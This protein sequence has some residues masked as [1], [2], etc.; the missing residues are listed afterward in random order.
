MLN[1]PWLG[2]G[3]QKVVTRVPDARNVRTLRAD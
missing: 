2:A 3:V 1:P